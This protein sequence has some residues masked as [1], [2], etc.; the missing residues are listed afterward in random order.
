MLETFIPLNSVHMRAMDND[1]SDQEVHEMTDS[2]LI[3]FNDAGY[4]VVYDASRFNITMDL[5]NAIDAIMA[6]GKVDP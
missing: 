6:A 1:A 2:V 4:A 3:Q 5:A